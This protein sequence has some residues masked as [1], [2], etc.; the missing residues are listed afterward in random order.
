MLMG[1]S[2]KAEVSLIMARTSVQRRSELVS[3]AVSVARTEN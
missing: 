1:Q 2:R 3:V